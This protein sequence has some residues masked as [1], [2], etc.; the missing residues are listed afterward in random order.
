M[1]HLV[2]AV[3]TAFQG[4]A[5]N[6][7]YQASD[8]ISRGQL[9][10]F[11]VVGIDSAGPLRSLNYLPYAPGRRLHASLWLP[12]HLNYQFQTL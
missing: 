2:T 7:G 6:V 4:V 1:A 3:T 8:L 9:P 12:V 10:G 5:W 11:I